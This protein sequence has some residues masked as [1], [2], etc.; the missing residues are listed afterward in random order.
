MGK[1]AFVNMSGSCD[2]KIQQ[3][4][5][6]LYLQD[7]EAR[8][9]LHRLHLDTD[10]VEKLFLLMD[11]DNSDGITLQEFMTGCLRLRGAA[12]TVHLE[13]LHQDVKFAIHTLSDMMLLLQ[14]HTEILTTPREE[15]ESCMKQGQQLG[16]LQRGLRLLSDQLKELDGTVQERLSRCQSGLDLGPEVK[17]EQ[18]LSL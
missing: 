5:M 6:V 12:S 4:D 11:T 7:P 16:I 1:E 13:F 18:T 17:R 9:L 2:G 15:S 8:A 10:Q 3:K 14:N